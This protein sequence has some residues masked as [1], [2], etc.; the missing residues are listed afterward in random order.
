LAGCR[1]YVGD[2]I[3][4]GILQTDGKVRFAI[5]GEFDVYIGK[6]YVTMSDIYRQF[7]YDLEGNRITLTQELIEK[8]VYNY[9][10]SE[11]DSFYKEYASKYTKVDYLGSNRFRVETNDSRK[12]VDSTNKTIYNEASDAPYGYP[13]ALMNGSK[14]Y[15]LT[16]KGLYNKDGKLIISNSKYDQIKPADGDCFVTSMDNKSFKM[17]DSGGKVLASSDYNPLIYLYQGKVGTLF[18]WLMDSQYRPNGAAYLYTNINLSKG[19]ASTA[20]LKKLFKKCTFSDMP[21]DKGVKAS[22]EKLMKSS[23]AEIPGL[24][25]VMSYLSRGYAKN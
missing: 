14:L 25:A 13:T 15:L 12:I 6:N 21:V 19:K 24:F 2:E 18:Y 17:Y 22:A 1:Y 5:L 11:R 3:Y 9:K 7:A 10:A 8:D 20:E 4:T 23:T 16:S